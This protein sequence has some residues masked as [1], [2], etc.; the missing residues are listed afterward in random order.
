[1]A[2]T[3]N[4]HQLIQLAQCLTRMQASLTDYELHALSELSAAQKNKIE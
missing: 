4:A 2:E 3:L 1:M